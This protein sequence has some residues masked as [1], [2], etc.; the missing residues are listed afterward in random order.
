MFKAIFFDAAGTLIYL[1][2]SVG[3]HYREVIAGYGVDLEASALDRAFRQAWADSPARP[4]GDGPRPDDDKG[5]WRDLVQRVFARTL[6]PKQAH[7]F[8]AEAC[9]EALYAHFAKPGVWATFPETIDVLKALRSV[10]LRLALISNFDRRL[11]SIFDQLRLTQFF[12]HI[13]LSSE[14]GSDK[15]DSLIFH[16]ALRAME[17][18]AAEVLHV[19]DDPTKDWG[20]E[21]LGLRVFRL[22]RPAVSLRD[23]QAELEQSA[24]E[25][26]Q[27]RF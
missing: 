16:H 27:R 23:L 5:W 14:V 11:Y 15:P 18:T 25:N 10:G 1:P 6:A 22:D 19:G 9:F 8:Q 21:A 13:I 12:E 24:Q 3:E 2:R 17:I 20:A 4:S 26:S 7:D